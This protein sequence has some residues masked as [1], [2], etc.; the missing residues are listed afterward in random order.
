MTFET[1]AVLAVIMGVAEACKAVGFPPKWVP[2]LNLVLG[3]AAMLVF[4]AADMREN[5]FMGLVLGL[6][7]GGLYSG[8]KSIASIFNPPGV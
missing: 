1:G 3:L 7:A 6:M 2:L 8:V 4:G 5:A